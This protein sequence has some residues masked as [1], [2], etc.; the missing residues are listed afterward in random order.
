MKYSAVTKTIAFILAAAA[1]TA[2]IL[3]FVV[4]ALYSDF[5]DPYYDS[6]YSDVILYALRNDANLISEMLNIKSEIDDGAVLS[7]E[8]EQYYERLCEAYADADSTNVRWIVANE[9]DT[10]VTGGNTDSFPDFYESYVITMSNFS[11]SLSF[12]I[13]L[14]NIDE[15]IDSLGDGDYISCYTARKYYYPAVTMEEEVT[16]YSYDD[17]VLPEGNPEGNP[18]GIDEYGSYTESYA[19]E[20]YLAGFDNWYY[21][22]E[23]LDFY[24]D[25]YDEWGFDT[26]VPFADENGYTSVLV[27]DEGDTTAY[28]VPTIDSVL[29][30]MEIDDY[31][32]T[33]ST[34]T[35]T[36]NYE[37]VAPAYYGLSDGEYLYVWLDEKLSVADDY[38]Y[39]YRDILSPIE[40]FAENSAL[41]VI[42]SCLVISILLF[43]YSAAVSGMAEDC[44]RDEDGTKRR[45]KCIRPAWINRIPFDVFL[46]LSAAVSCIGLVPIIMAADGEIYPTAT[47]IYISGNAPLVYTVSFL[48]IFVVAAVIE[49]LIVSIIARVRN[50]SLLKNNILVMLLTWTCCTAR[51]VADK[52]LNS[53]PLIWKVALVSALAVISAVFTFIFAFSD[54]ELCF[55]FMFIWAAVTVA[56]AAYACLTAYQFRKLTD[57]TRTIVLG[58]HD[59]K[60]ETK[61]MSPTLRPLA[62]SLNELD[63]AVSAAADE[64]VRSE[65]LKVELITNVS[66]DLKT[67]LTSIINYVDLLKSENIESETAREYIDVLDRKS[68]RL[69]RLTEDLV[70]ASKAQSGNIHYEPTPVGLCQL[71]EQAIGE[72]SDLLESAELT[73]VR[74]FPE[75]EIT[76]MADG[77]LLWR[78]FDNLLSN[79]VKYSLPKTRVYLDIERLSGDGTVAVTMK[80][81]SGT[82]LT[83][84]ARDLTERFVRGDA[85]RT[86][87]GSGL[88][89]SIAQSFCELMGGSLTVSTDGDLFKATVKFPII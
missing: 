64:K 55:L 42:I 2:A 29:C 28:Y 17:Y 7:A 61:L 71:A 57:A 18:E 45:V 34:S 24:I 9:D 38:F 89:L 73:I 6:E 81:I 75:S 43:I 58:G 76:V 54:G 62:E 56:S 69:K 25:S 20:A 4:T 30:P 85:S 63:R 46:V 60:I 72:Y 36:W 53:V 78:V 14:M 82:P 23:Y 8:N 50:R 59:V 19:F 87:E 26:V 12:E 51:K 86:T 52:I 41:P 80:N 21:P 31:I 33:Y 27:I 67:P 47:L 32:F 49:G 66:H 16:T 13:K 37:S 88:G 15:L 44:I 83:V 70:E 35:N 77:K 79:V 39:I 74:N 22:L 1:L 5:I 68:Q 48:C 10:E 65:R 84:S 11:Y 40:S 3:M